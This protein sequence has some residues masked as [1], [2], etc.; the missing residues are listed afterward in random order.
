MLAFGN[1][2]V[3]YSVGLGLFAST[4]CA[5]FYIREFLQKLS[6]LIER[7]MLCLFIAA[8]CFYIAFSTLCDGTLHV[9]LAAARSLLQDDAALDVS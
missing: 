9:R 6:P 4:W 7:L 2:V 5:A 8:I 3:I 1:A